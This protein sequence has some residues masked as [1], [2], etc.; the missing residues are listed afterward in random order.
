MRITKELLLKNAES[1]VR[2]RTESE[3]D[4]NAVYLTGSLLTDEHMLGD[5]ADIDLVFIHE[6]MLEK[7]E[8]V[9][10]T[11]DIHFDI[12][13]YPRS[14][15]EHSRDLRKE[16]WLGNALFTAKPMYD[17]EHYL[18]FIQAS[19]RGMFHIPENILA[20]AEPFLEAARQTWMKYHNGAEEPGAEQ[21]LAFLKALENI[22]NALSC[23][24]GGPISERRF[25]LHFQNRVNALG[26]PGL[27][28]GMLGLLGV[29]D[30]P[31]KEMASWLPVWEQTY[32][33]VSELQNGP[34][35]GHPHRKAYFQKAISY[36]LNQ[37]DFSKAAWPLLNNW[38]RLV[39]NLHPG[40][41]RVE[42][43]QRIFEGLNL[44]GEGYSTRMAGLD[45]YLDRVEELFD[46][47]KEG[48][49]V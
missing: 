21:T 29:N 46:K 18:D 47:W 24:T 37:K 2:A 33:Q 3:L 48:Q 41:P 19:V 27:F 13:H 34:I 35:E 11:E 5:A 6:E 32:D 43:W 10:L 12:Q 14:K 1:M 28:A 38:T 8:F 49:G 45:A 4:L 36:L 17:P 30:L 9:R 40:D 26:Q 7:R 42:E 16:P 39:N 15:F 23:L 20:R 31:Q 22:G 25:L 44:T